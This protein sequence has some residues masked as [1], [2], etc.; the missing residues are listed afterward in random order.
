MDE[1]ICHDIPYQKQSQD[2]VAKEDTK[3]ENHMPVNHMRAECDPFQPLGLNNSPMSPI[4]KSTSKLVGQDNG[5]SVRKHKS[6]KSPLGSSSKSKQKKKKARLFSPTQNISSSKS[7]RTSQIEL[8]SPP[9]AEQTSNSSTAKRQHIGTPM[10]PLVSN[11][12]KAE[13][14]NTK[15]EPLEDRLKKLKL[16]SLDTPLRKT[17]GGSLSELVYD[18]NL[19]CSNSVYS[20]KNLSDEEESVE[21]DDE[22]ENVEIEAIN[23]NEKKDM[24]CRLHHSHEE[25]VTLESSTSVSDSFEF[26]HDMMLSL[27]NSNDCDTR[28]ISKV[29]CYN[30]IEEWPEVPYLMFIRA[31]E[32]IKK[33]VKNNEIQRLV[34]LCNLYGDELKKS[35]FYVG[36]LTMEKEDLESKLSKLSTIFEQKIIQHK[37]AMTKIRDLEKFNR[38]KEKEMKDT[39]EVIQTQ[40]MQGL[41][42]AVKKNRALQKELQ[43]ERAKNQRLEK[44]LVMN[45]K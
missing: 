23:D 33:A 4:G 3:R 15:R 9:H 2:A 32:E 42:E 7:T 21:S 5:V 36:V 40:M 8:R 10:R 25:D 20:P 14:S 1:N 17:N 38:D 28:D 13:M 39:V 45:N 16:T 34:Q 31:E 19:C 29:D 24:K 18:P 35:R 12:K 22:E 11:K 43:Q 37:K 27:E 26:E 44:E 30:L 6:G 41:G